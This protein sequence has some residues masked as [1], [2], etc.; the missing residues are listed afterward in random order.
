MANSIAWAEY[1]Q[2]TSHVGM[3][4]P[5]VTF[6]LTSNF[7]MEDNIMTWFADLFGWF[8]PT[9]PGCAAWGT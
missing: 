5:I 7:N 4:T 1:P 8:L 6:Q 2:Y 3:V 9:P